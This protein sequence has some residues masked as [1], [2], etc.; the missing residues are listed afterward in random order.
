MIQTNI[1][2]QIWRVTYEVEEDGTWREHTARVL[3]TPNCGARITDG[4]EGWLEEHFPGGRL[5]GLD[6]FQ[7]EQIL[8][9]TMPACEFYREYQR[10]SNEM[11]TNE[12]YCAPCKK[13]VRMYNTE[14]F[15]MKNGRPALRGKCPDCGASTFRILPKGETDAT[16]S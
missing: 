1:E 3:G 4:M 10:R 8:F 11:Q 14:E 15:T 2:L 13:P 12:A 6:H 7:G 5:T 9:V 16:A